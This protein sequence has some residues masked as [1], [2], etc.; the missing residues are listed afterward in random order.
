MAKEKEMVSLRVNQ[1][2]FEEF[3]EYRNELQ[4]TK[5]EA[6]RRL[7]VTGLEQK[8][9]EGDGDD[10]AETLSE[11]LRQ[12]TEGEVKQWL[13]VGGIS[14]ILTVLA[15]SQWIGLAGALFVFLTILLAG[16]GLLFDVKR[17]LLPRFSA[18]TPEEVND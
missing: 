3:E 17:T 13:T 11:Q 8:R 18:S 12:T 5:S 15:P 7:V 6:G 9:N 1:D 2:T 14:A 10:K 16:A 4:L